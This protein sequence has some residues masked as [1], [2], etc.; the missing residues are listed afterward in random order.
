VRC[1]VVAEAVITG[2]RFLAGEPHRVVFKRNCWYNSLWKTRS[3]FCYTEAVRHIAI[4]TLH[5]GVS[6]DGRMDWSFGSEGSLA[7]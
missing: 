1:D 3:P 6:I 4:M 5:N 2:N 7:P